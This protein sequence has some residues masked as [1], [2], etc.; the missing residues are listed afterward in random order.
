MYAVLVAYSHCSLRIPQALKQVFAT[1]LGLPS[2]CGCTLDLG[3]T[4][5][6]TPG[7]PVPG[8][9][10]LTNVN[11]NCCSCCGACDPPCPQNGKCTVQSEQTYTVSATFGA[12]TGDIGASIGLTAGWETATTAGCEVSADCTKCNKAS[13]TGGFNTLTTTYTVS[14]TGWV[15]PCTWTG[16]ITVVQNT[17]SF[18]NGGSSGCS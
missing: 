8:T 14:E 16:T 10:T 4:Q 18:C 13:C 1:L 17:S 5:T 12:S 9:V 7:V 11:T 6:I 15:T 2:C 3:C